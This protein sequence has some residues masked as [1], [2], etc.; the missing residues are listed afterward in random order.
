MAE[1]A[2]GHD[3]AAQRAGAA[4]PVLVSVGYEGRS[5]PE[6]VSLLRRHDVSVLVDVRLNAVSRKP[7]FSRGRLSQ[8]LA[9]SGIAYRH[10]R[11]LG[12]PPGNRE[13]FRR[14][15]TGSGLAV[16]G[17]VLCTQEARAELDVLRDLLATGRVAV[18]CFEREHDR[19]HRQAVLDALAGATALPVVR[20]E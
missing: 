8:A 16:F 9:E 3:R 5:L 10:A 18:S 11:A 19:C 17:E 6:F 13:P 7:G 2:V 15:D 20:L 4:A 14:G 1:Q 12:N